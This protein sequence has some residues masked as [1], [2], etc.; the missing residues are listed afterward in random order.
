MSNVQFRDVIHLRRTKGATRDNRQS[1][2]SG[3]TERRHGAVRMLQL[4]V[5][6][7]TRED[8]GFQR[9]YLDR[10]HFLLQQSVAFLRNWL[11]RISQLQSTL[12]Y[13]NFFTSTQKQQNSTGHSSRQPSRTGSGQMRSRGVTWRVEFRTPKT[14]HSAG[15]AAIHETTCF[16]CRSL[17]RVQIASAQLITTRHWK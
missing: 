8:F 11:R 16:D 10:A 4:M 15:R 14:R 9:N 12:G 3:E 1:I 2:R 7:M 13:E 6:L 17:S 5:A